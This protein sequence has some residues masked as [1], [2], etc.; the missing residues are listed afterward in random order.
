MYEAE[1]KE[2]RGQDRKMNAILTEFSLGTAVE[3]AGPN[4]GTEL[5]PAAAAELVSGCVF[6]L[7]D[8]RLRF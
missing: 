5:R 1:A 6:D 3:P 2:E 7:R 4:P 8:L